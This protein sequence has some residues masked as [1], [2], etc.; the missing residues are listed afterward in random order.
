MNFLQSVAEAYASTGDDLSQYCFVFP[1]KR[2]G[3]FFLKHL[4]ACIGTER[5]QLAP[6]V[7][8]M[9]DVALTLSQRV[10]DSRID[11]IFRLYNI[12]RS[13]MGKPLTFE[14][15]DDL[16]DFDRF[17]AWGDTLIS[18]FSEVD[19]YDGDAEKLFQNITDLRSIASN[20]LS[21]EQIAIIERYFGYTPSSG[22]V[23]RFWKS[24]QDVKE[25]SAIRSRFV[26]LWQLLSQLYERFNESLEA[27]GL[28][29]PG[30]GFRLALETVRELGRDAFPWQRMVV[31]G[32][33]DLSTTELKIFESIRD[34]R[35][36]DGR[37]FGE[38]FWDATGPVLD[39]TESGPG[40][41]MSRLISLFPA[42]EWALPYL[43]KSRSD[44]MPPVVME[45]SPSN[46]MQAKLAGKEIAR[47]WATK[48]GRDAI[49]KAH[50][51]VVLP[52]E[53]LL[54]PLL[55]SL[56]ED[57]GNV[58][59][60]M[61]YSMRYTAVASFVRHL[62]LLLQR[63]RSAH[64]ATGFFH[65]DMVALL[66]HPITHI[67]A[68]PG[69]PGK[70]AEHIHE[71][72]TYVVTPELL[73]KYS[74]RLARLLVPANMLD[75]P[76]QS[77]QMLDGLL[78]EVQISLGRDENTS[79]LRRDIE[80][81]QVEAYR[82]SLRIVTQC[83]KKYHVSM[84]FDSVFRLVDRLVQGEKI[85]FEGE[86]LQGLQVMGMLETRALDFDQLFMLSLNDKTMPSA[87]RR[88]SFIP[89]SVRH[90]YGLPV[91][92]HGERLYSYY[93]YRLLSRAENVFLY[94]DA[95]AGEGMRSGGKSRFLMQLELLYGGLDVTP[96][97]RQFEISSRE[98]AASP[99]K[100][101]AEVMRLLNQ[102]KEKEDK[103]NKRN[104]SASSLQ[105]Y[106]KCQVM[107]YYETVRGISDDPP[108]SDYIDAITLGNIVH[109]SLLILY[110]P[111][112]R[113]KKYISPSEGITLTEDY[114]QQLIDSPE[115]IEHVVRRSINKEHFG[116]KEENGDDL[117]RELPGAAGLVADRILELIKS[118]IRY[119]KQLAPITLIGGELDGNT[120]WQYGPN[121][122]ES[123]NIRYA[124]DR[125]DIANGAWRIIDYKTGKVGLK[126][127]AIA[128]IFSLE[129]VSNPGNSKNIFQLMFYANILMNRVTQEGDTLPPDILTAIY[130]VQQIA[131][132]NNQS[133]IQIKSGRTYVDEPFFA[134]HN[135]EFV[136]NLNSMLKDIFDP[137]KDFVPTANEENCK[138]CRLKA[139]C[140]KES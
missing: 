90:G 133:H 55:Y 25:D 32:F 42:P 72:H 9:T 70:I 95:R 130:D 28:C 18:D 91:S 29:T 65:E 94:Y 54:M 31:V 68:E 132:G 97:S 24:L 134:K 43:D 3:R 102:F 1:N 127:D 100:K 23:D 80:N 51:A 85:T 74:P 93:F 110:F 7:M 139:L 35:C 61:G 63:Q 58:N 98:S 50:V 69:A 137:T 129:N 78:E 88:R 17:I 117:D 104:L 107:F 57:M 37:A 15:D 120:R 99:V 92:S 6:S 41:S 135:A 106:P 75:T 79:T 81:A 44:K 13:L 87:S 114:L 116:M 12:Y 84:R 4:S 64:G 67:L 111:S 86:P 56:P 115:K 96:R 131:M 20:Y 52:D 45:A 16:L 71:H 36:D 125:V 136:D 19:K 46:S 62:R 5:P 126:T 60:T 138:W 38:F 108:H 22:D 140:G 124:L 82:N 118:V 11:M 122:D 59:L 10:P 21:E 121:P 76:E 49:E 40:R 123:V 30:G 34:M 83:V 26:A 103:D 47:L 48:E 101:S 8:S 105:K 109:N 27:D 77:I 53:S 66:G 119:D 2:S 14:S 33:S 128:S 89:D 113:R 112:D 39:N 73:T